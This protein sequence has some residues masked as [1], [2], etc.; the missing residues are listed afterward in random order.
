MLEKTRRVECPTPC[1]PETL[2]LREVDFAA[3]PLFFGT[4]PVL[5][6][7]AG[8]IPLNNFSQSIAERDFVVQHP[9]ILTISSTDTRFIE[10]RF[11]ASQRC[12]PPAYD[13]FDIVGVNYR[14]PL[15]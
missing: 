4:L 3:A 8:S 12:A 14:C 5:D 7:D 1:L 6:V 10:E 2:T 9:A 13:S 15:P 11:A